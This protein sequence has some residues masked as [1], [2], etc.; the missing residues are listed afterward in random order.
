L[1][2]NL[3]QGLEA[4]TSPRIL[5]CAHSIFAGIWSDQTL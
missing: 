2:V 3:Y 5:M 1:H 4:N